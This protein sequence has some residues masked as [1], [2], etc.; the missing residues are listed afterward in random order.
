M[1]GGAG[2]PPHIG[3]NGAE[4][5]MESL[6]AEPYSLS[7]LVKTEMLIANSHNCF[8]IGQN[9][10]GPAQNIQIFGPKARV[11]NVVCTT[12]KNPGCG[13]YLQS[14]NLMKSTFCYYSQDSARNFS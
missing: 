5:L 7:D 9:S 2:A 4:T 8:E 12:K 10:R 11:W 3:G 1:G 13:A 14:Q 6:D